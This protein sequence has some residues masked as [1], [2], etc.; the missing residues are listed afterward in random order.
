M[1]KARVIY[2]DEITEIEIDE[3]TTAL[4]VVERAISIFKLP[5]KEKLNYQVFI[6]VSSKK[7]IMADPSIPL[8]KQGLGSYRYGY[9][10]VIAHVC[11]VGE[12]G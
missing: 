2:G 7:I 10:V 1:V 4:D 3:S 11:V 9:T 12:V 6:P 5:D 8:M